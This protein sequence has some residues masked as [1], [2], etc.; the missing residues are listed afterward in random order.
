[1]IS[2][3]TNYKF[4]GLLIAVILIL[5]SI[6]LFVMDVSAFSNQSFVVTNVTTTVTTIQTP[7]I[8]P[9]PLIV[10][11]RNGTPAYQNNTRILQGQCVEVGGT[12]DV[13]GVIGYSF[14]TQNN[15]FAYYGRY[16]DSFDPYFGNESILYRYVLPQQRMGLYKFYIDPVIFQNRQGYWYQYTGEYERAANKRAFFVSDRCTVTSRNTTTNVSEVEY[17]PPESMVISGDSIVHI[18]NQYSLEQRHVSDIVLARGDPLFID[19]PGEYRAWVFGGITSVLAKQVNTTGNASIFDS[20]DT[21]NW[22]A[23]SYTIILEDSGKNGIY[24]IGYETNN[25]T[26]ITKDLLVPALRSLDIVDVTGYQPSMIKD[27][28]IQMMRENTD[29]TYTTIKLE[30]QEPYVEIVGYQ[31]IRVSNMSLLEITGY[32]NKIPGT[33]VTLYV[34]INNKTGTSVRYPAMTVMAMDTGDGNLRTFH[35]Y[36]VLDYN[37]IAPGHHEITAKLPDG[38]LSTVSFYIREEPEPGY[39]EPKY[40]KFVDGNPFIPPTIIEKEVIKVVTK[41]VIKEVTIKIPVDYETL[42]AEKNR[43]L[44]DDIRNA[45]PFVIGG[46]VGLILALYMVSVGVR[47]YVRRKGNF[48]LNEKMETKI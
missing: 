26:P 10:I 23:G 6:E 29:D 30:V 33:P 8:T 14:T 38:K 16:V 1:M 15:I 37:E 31:E 48:V 28:L 35:G 7:I 47:A 45:L 20:L 39:T 40:Y 13:S 46:I 12:Y 4:V 34:D 18:Q 44:Y 41:E 43:Q 19:N 11:P 21:K 9:V 24:E 22:Q 17:V 42:A 25:R 36:F 32:T 5:L 2:L 27:K 3:Q